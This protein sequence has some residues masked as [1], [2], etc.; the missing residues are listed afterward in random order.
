MLG[1][2]YSEKNK[3]N[4]DY[5]SIQIKSHSLFRVALL[6]YGAD[7]RILTFDLPLMIR[8]VS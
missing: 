2:N 1:I 8:K 7:K 3:K 5:E 6:F 4:Y